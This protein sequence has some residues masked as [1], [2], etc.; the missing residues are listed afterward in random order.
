MRSV[1]AKFQAIPRAGFKRV[2]MARKEVFA[3][4]LVEKLLAYALGRKIERFD[5]PT[6][7]ELTAALQADGWR[8]NGLL[9]G[10]ARSYPMRFT[11]NAGSLSS[12]VA[13]ITS[14]RTT[15]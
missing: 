12:P 4:L 8:I 2:L 5:R 14:E 7:S 1:P 3:R 6:V 11:R 13:P 15:P 10:I 9:R